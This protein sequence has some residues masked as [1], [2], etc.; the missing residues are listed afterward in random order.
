M[1]ALLLLDL[2]HEGV[3]TTE[4][5]VRRLHGGRR[6]ATRRLARAECSGWAEK[7]VVD[8]V[9]DGTGFFPVETRRY[10]PA[11]INIAGESIEN[12]SPI[13]TSNTGWMGFRYC[14]RMHNGDDVGL[15]SGGNLLIGPADV[16][17]FIISFLNSRKT[18]VAL[19]PRCGEGFH[20][21]SRKHHFLEIENRRVE[22]CIAAR[23]VFIFRSVFLAAARTPAR[24]EHPDR[25]MSVPSTFHDDELLLHEQWMQGQQTQRYRIP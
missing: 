10:R 14:S 3:Q 2:V 17:M 5:S 1:I 18:I 21:V 6:F 16:S 7:I 23:V 15:P 11:N 12:T 24:L 9:L 22:M 4:P 20:M 8:C 13:Q 19:K 25:L